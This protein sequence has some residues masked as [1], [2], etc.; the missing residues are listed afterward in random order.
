MELGETGV[1]YDLHRN[2]RCVSTRCLMMSGIVFWLFMKKHLTSGNSKLKSICGDHL[3]SYTRRDTTVAYDKAQ[4]NYTHYVW[5]QFNGLVPDYSNSI[6]N[7]LELLQSWTTPS[8]WPPHHPHLMIKYILYMCIG[9]CCVLL[10]W[11]YIIGVVDGC[12]LWPLLLTW[13]NFNPS[14]DK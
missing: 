12:L 2:Y 5:Q 3:R 14:M 11:D 8:N 1:D 6:T 13:F 9:F 4:G 7:A 10:C